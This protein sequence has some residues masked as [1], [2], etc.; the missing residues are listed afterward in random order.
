[1]N[2]LRRLLK[3]MGAWRKYIFLL[4]LRSPFDALMTWL[5]ANLMRSVFGCL[6]TDHADALLK[7]CIVYGL[8]CALLFFYNVMV[9]TKYA[10]FASKTE[11]RLVKKMFDKVLS[12]PLKRINSH[13]SGEWI[14]RLNSDI[15]AA[16]TMMNGPMNLPHLAVA[17]INILLSCLLLL[18]S[19]ILFLGITWLFA[20]PQLVINYVIVLT[21]IPRLKEASQNALAN[22]TSAIQPLLT[23]AETIV[24][25]DA[26]ELMMKNYA[27]SSKNLIKINLKLHVRRAIGDMSMQLFGIGGYLM[28]LFVGF[29]L[30]EHGSMAFSDVVYCFQVRGS[31]LSG[32]FMLLICLNNLKINSVCVKRVNN[33][34]EEK[35]KE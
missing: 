7:Q 32:M 20:I 34:L 13:Y 21:S 1:M 26:T 12:L 14:T 3:K 8:L 35:E 28:I 2:A 27:K 25:Y 30:I 6:E 15:Q 19:S 31:V 9:W 10:V 18:R 4:L 23:N 33:T 17:I 16:L 5:C 24:L 22:N 29:R 11:I